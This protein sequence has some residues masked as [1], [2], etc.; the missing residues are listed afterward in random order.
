MNYITNCDKKKKMSVNDK[1]DKAVDHSAIQHQS[2]FCVLLHSQQAH[3]HTLPL[4]PSLVP[5]L[6][7]V[8]ESV[9]ALKKL[10]R[11]PEFHLKI[12]HQVS[13]LQEKK[14]LPINFVITKRHHVLRE[15]IVLQKLPHI[16]NAP[17]LRGRG[18]HTQCRPVG[19]SLGLPGSPYPSISVVCL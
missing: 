7:R 12:V 2:L 16:L 13:L 5:A 17:V 15:S 4:P 8:R 19:L 14:R 18:V 9:D 11:W 10:Q 3:T 1:N 6:G